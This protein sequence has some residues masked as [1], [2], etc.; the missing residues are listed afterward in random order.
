MENT[1]KL[2][3]LLVSGDTLQEWDINEILDNTKSKN[4]DI[5]TLV[6]YNWDNRV[7]RCGMTYLEIEQINYAYN[8]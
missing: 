2:R 8:K 6:R 1:T 3:T 7:S 5:E 4:R